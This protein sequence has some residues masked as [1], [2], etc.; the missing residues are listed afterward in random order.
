MKSVHYEA[1]QKVWIMGV[2]SLDHSHPLATNP[3]SYALHLKVLPEHHLTRTAAIPHRSAILSWSASNRIL[4]HLGLGLSRDTY[5]NLLPN[6]TL[7][8]TEISYHI[9]L[10]DHTR[11]FYVP[12]RRIPQIVEM[13]LSF[14][15]TS[16]DAHLRL[17]LKLPSPSRNSW[18]KTPRNGVL[19]S[20]HYLLHHPCCSTLSLLH[21]QLQAG[22]TSSISWNMN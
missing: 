12:H 11:T 1:T 14:H 5:Y 4:D 16:P 17:H 3:L 6:S 19:I 9:W 10:G 15:A 22:S 7:R 8:V 2:S 20:P 18:K 13:T 21:V